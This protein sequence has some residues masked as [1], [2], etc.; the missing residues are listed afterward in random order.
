MSRT[1]IAVPILVVLALLA[2]A[3]AAAASARRAPLA[4]LATGKARVEEDGRGG[5]G[6][7]RPWSCAPSCVLF[8]DTPPDRGVL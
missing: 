5:E 2:I 4:A 7:R 1:R 3:L 8:R 6:P